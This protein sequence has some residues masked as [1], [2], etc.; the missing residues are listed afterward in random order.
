MHPGI[1][2]FTMIVRPWRPWG[3]ENDRKHDTPDNLSIESSHMYLTGGTRRKSEGRSRHGTATPPPPQPA[4][5]PPP[6]WSPPGPPWS[7]QHRRH[8][9]RDKARTT[10]NNKR[11]KLPTCSTTSKKPPLCYCIGRNPGQFGREV[12][13]WH[14]LLFPDTT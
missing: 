8:H 14:T 10:K 6:P 1:P 3:L 12:L 4:A 9:R 11:I 13:L 7:P 2:K 5:Q